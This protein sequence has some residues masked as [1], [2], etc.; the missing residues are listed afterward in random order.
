MPS[1]ASFL[2][3]EERDSMACAIC[4]KHDLFSTVTGEKVCSVCTL[5]HVGGFTNDATIARARQR[6]GLKDGEFLPQDNVAE[7]RQ[8]LGR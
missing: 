8:I 6:L 1:G 3:A 7:A 5:K 2:G 4:G